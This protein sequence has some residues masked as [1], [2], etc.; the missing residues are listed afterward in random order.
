LATDLAIDYNTGDLI[1]S[2]NSDLSVRTGQGVVEQRIRVRLRVH[3]GMWDV[4][5][6]LGSR[7]YDM[8]RMPDTR[9]QQTAELTVREALEPM[10][11][12]IVHDVSVSID[13]DDSRKVNITIT[14]AMIED[15]ED[16]ADA[17]TTTTTLGVGE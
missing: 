7:L 11:D 10:T 9:A 2:P 12:I 4:D 5:P 13:E 16:P 3:Y 8:L 1:V 15:S 14:Y 17:L 6:S